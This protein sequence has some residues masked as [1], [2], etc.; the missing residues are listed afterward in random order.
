MSQTN[1]P[2]LRI[3][4]ETGQPEQATGFEPVTRQTFEEAVTKADSEHTVAKQ[5]LEA[6]EQA[7]VIFEQQYDQVIARVNTAIK[8]EEEAADALAFQEGRLVAFDE[9]LQSSQQANVTPAS[10]DHAPT[11]DAGGAV[12]GQPSAQDVATTLS[13]VDPEQ[14]ETQATEAAETTPDDEV[15]PSVSQAVPV[16]TA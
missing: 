2:V 6:A 4:P 1:E 9:L 11:P 13:S 7:Q 5:E 10:V 16:R 12:A 8:A 14:S 3:N 15:I